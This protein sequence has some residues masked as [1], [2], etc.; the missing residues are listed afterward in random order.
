MSKKNLHIKRK[1]NYK[2]FVYIDE[3]GV[4]LYKKV[5]KKAKRYYQ[6][7]KYYINASW[8]RGP[9]QHTKNVLYN[10]NFV[11]AE[12]KSNNKIYWVQDEMA[13]DL[14]KQIGITATTVIGGRNGIITPNIKQ[15]LKGVDIVIIKSNGSAGTSYAKRIKISFKNVARS[16]KIIDLTKNF[17]DIYFSSI[18]DLLDT[19]KCDTYVRYVIRHLEKITAPVIDNTSRIDNILLAINNYYENFG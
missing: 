15:Q 4:P 18:A 1:T 5:V 2:E 19:V 6:Y 8:E 10:I 3:K 14:L 11:N 16:I 7:R 12:I 13:V 17:S 9:Y